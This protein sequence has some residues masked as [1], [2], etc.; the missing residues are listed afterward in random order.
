MNT[1]WKEWKGNTIPTLVIYF[2]YVFHFF[3][4]SISQYCF[5]FRFPPLPIKCP[6][7]LRPMFSPIL[8]LPALISL[9]ILPFILLL[10]PLDI[11]IVVFS[12]SRALP[13]LPFSPIFPFFFTSS[14]FLTIS[15][16]HL[17]F[18]LFSFSLLLPFFSHPFFPSLFHP[19]SFH[20]LHFP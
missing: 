7:V 1:R 8:F 12:F 2:F 15:F 6:A 4:H 17:F 14:C 20:P 19:L 18:L 5:L 10:L 9:P 3:S 11:L 13:S 16:P